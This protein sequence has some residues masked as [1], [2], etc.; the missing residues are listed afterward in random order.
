MTTKRD[1]YDILGVHKSASK[2]EVKAAYRK[3][4]LQ[5]HPDRNKAADAE[6]RFKEINEAY[7]ALSDDEKRKAYDQ[8][9]HAAFDPASGFGSNPFTGG[10]RQ[11]PFT[12]TYSSTSG[13]PFAG[14]DFGE[15]G[16][17]PFEIFESFFGGSNPFGGRARR[18]PRY[19]LVISFMEA[20][21]GTEKKVAIDGQEHVIK[22]PAGADDGTRI[23]FNEFD[24]TLNVQPDAVFKRDGYD[25]YI[26]REIPFATAA[27]G[28]TIDVPTLEGEMTL[29][30]RPGTQPNTMIRLR[31][32]GIQE[33]NSHGRGDLY[34]RIIVRVP[35]K[36][37]R[38]QR[39]LVE[40]FDLSD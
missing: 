40:E 27:L 20:A 11:G 10:S 22:I 9:G 35:E 14:F 31:G 32:S 33:I 8:F 21:K 26:D 38:R 15:G 39:E 17:D 24:I 1:F 3:L 30:V 16:G 28:G 12:Y 19:T 29:K 4:A 25:L 2:D 36:L 34:V 23:R 6:Q 5:Y 18:K 7:Q 13:N 37:T